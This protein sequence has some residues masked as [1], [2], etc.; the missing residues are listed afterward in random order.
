MTAAY[1]YFNNA[2]GDTVERAGWCDDTFLLLLSNF[3]QEKGLFE[4]LD[5]YLARQADNESQCGLP[6]EPQ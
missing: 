1:N 6:E 4:E 2:I 5:S 3:L